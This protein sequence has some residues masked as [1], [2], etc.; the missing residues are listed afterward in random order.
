MRLLN[1]RTKRLQEFNQPRLPYAILSHTWGAEEV[2][3]QDL[4]SGNGASLLGYKKI[5]GACEQA[6]R[7]GLDFIWIDTCCIDKTSSSELTEAIN[8]MWNWYRESRVCYAYLEDVAADNAN[9]PGTG[10]FNYLEDMTADLIRA[11]GH[12]ASSFIRSRWFTRGWTLQEL[13]APYQVVFYAND[14]AEIGT[15]DNM[16]EALAKVTNIDRNFFD[17]GVL[18][19]YSIAQRMSWAA[20]RKTTRIEDQAYCLL[21]LFGVNMPLL[22]GEGEMAFAGSRTNTGFLAP[23]PSCFSQSGSIE[24]AVSDMHAPPYA[25]TNQ[26]IQITLQILRQGEFE[27]SFIPTGDGDIYSAEGVR[28][29]FSPV[30]MVAILN[31]RNSK[32]WRVGIFMEGDGPGPGPYYRS[33]HELGF[34]SVPNS[35]VMKAK[36]ETVLVGASQPHGM[37]S[38]WKAAQTAQFVALKPLPEADFGYRIATASPANGWIKDELGGYS[39]LLSVEHDK[40]QARDYA[41]VHFRNERGTGFCLFF[42]VDG[43]EVVN[44]HI[45]MNIKGTDIPA[46]PEADLFRHTKVYEARLEEEK[47]TVVVELKTSRFGN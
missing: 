43:G 2:S 8:S 21:G 9:L 34:V 11:L 17:H 45:V 13:I 1:T 23:S 24:R 44:A 35:D 40:H 3:L 26:G 16:R 4:V 7:D 33:N 5:E 20:K 29:S 10:G 27:L 15:R 47:A 14:W 39:A 32:G 19:R 31:C 38:L 22:Y 25:F 28:F 42:M 18:G 12:Y 37:S 46:T 6:L 30:G 36:L 41:F